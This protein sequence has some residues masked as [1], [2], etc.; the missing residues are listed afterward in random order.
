MFF[1]SKLQSSMN[2]SLCSS[3][4]VGEFPH[5]F[6]MSFDSKLNLRRYCKL[7]WQINKKICVTFAHFLSATSGV[8][9]FCLYRNLLIVEVH[10]VRT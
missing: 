5:R 3:W 10:N 6:R 9:T 8:Q 7:L 4:P 1:F 2:V